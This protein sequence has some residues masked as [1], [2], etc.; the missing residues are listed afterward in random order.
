MFSDRSA[1]SGEF[2]RKRGLSSGHRFFDWDKNVG[3]WLASKFFQCCRVI[4]A[5]FCF[6]A[7]LYAY[8]LNAVASA[9]SKPKSWLEWEQLTGDWSGGRAALA[10]RG[11]SPYMTWTSQITHSLHGGLRSGTDVEGVVE[12]GADFDLQKLGAWNGATI[13]TSGFWIQ[14]NNDP[15]ADFVGNFDEVSNLAALR[16]VRFYQAYVK[17]NFF[18]GKLIAKLGQLALDDD[19]MISSQS[20]MFVNAS[21][22]SLPVLSANTKAPIYPLGALGVWAQMNFTSAFRLQM[23]VYDGNAGTQTSNRDGFDYSLSNR[24]GAA[25]MTEFGLDGGSGTYKLGALFHTG[26][27]TDYRN[28]DTRSGNYALYF[29]L[30]QMLTGNRDTPT[31]GVFLRSGLSPLVGCNEVDWYV[32]A[33]I[34]DRGLFNGDRIGIGF[35]HSSFAGTFVESQSNSGTPVTDAESVIELSYQKQITNWSMIQPDLQYV[36]NPQNA[37]AHNALVAAVRM[38]LSF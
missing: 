27:F 33:G 9:A 28:G 38:K 3:Y 15:S 7:V 30:D 20:S 2:R 23:G 32:D 24:Q 12:F 37:A 25:I 4:I 10:D 17:Q 26:E 29:V 16:S 22:G 5:S 36:I 6:V 34:T 14:D 18:A 11:V 35:S 1:V 13:H 21:F 19:F 31:L 8:D